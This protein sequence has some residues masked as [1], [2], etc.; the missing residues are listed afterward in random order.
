V[1]AFLNNLKG[2]LTALEQE[3]QALSGNLELIMVRFDQ[4]K[5][6]GLLHRLNNALDSQLDELVNPEGTGALVLPLIMTLQPFE[7]RP[8]T[9]EDRSRWRTAKK[10][11]VRVVIGRG[12]VEVKAASKIA[13]RTETAA[14]EHQ[15]Y[16]IL[17]WD[18]YQNLLGEV[19][20]LISKDD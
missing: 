12:K 8:I 7:I 15:G 1:S 13:G 6:T 14:S 20:K 10:S 16:I 2:K 18:Q 5:W 4:G 17:S 19:S 3:M 11:E 9:S